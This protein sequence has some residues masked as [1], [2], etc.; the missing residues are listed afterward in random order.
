MITRN[1]IIPLVLEA[2]PSFHT[3]WGEEQLAS[4]SEDHV[5][6]VA[7][8]A[9]AGHLQSLQRH[10]QTSEFPGVNL[11]ISRLGQEGDEDVRKLAQELRECIDSVLS[12]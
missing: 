10:G 5:L 11:T 12:P 2:C 7:F 4:G 1:R 9:F 6:Y 3:V 8:G